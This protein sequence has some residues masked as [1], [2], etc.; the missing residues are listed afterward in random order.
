VD[1]LAFRYNEIQIRILLLSTSKGWESA[2]KGAIFSLQA[3]IMSVHGPPRL[4][5]GFNSDPDPAFHF[6]A[7]PDPAFKTMRIR[8]RTLMK[9]NE[10]FW[11]LKIPMYLG[12]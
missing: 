5:F 11:H 1:P 10:T 2:T 8:I 7:D 3:S 12:T 9:S 4:H 6:D